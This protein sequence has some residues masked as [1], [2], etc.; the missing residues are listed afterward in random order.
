MTTVAFGPARGKSRLR[1]F[2]CRVFGHRWREMEAVVRIKP[3]GM[4]WM[5]KRLTRPAMGCERCQATGRLEFEPE[6][7]LLDCLYLVPRN[8]NSEPVGSQE[9]SQPAE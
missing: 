3:A 2:T 7:G 6:P 5:T 8:A 1:R 4:G 9:G